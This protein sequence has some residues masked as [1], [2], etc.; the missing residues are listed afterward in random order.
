MLVP[1]KIVLHCSATEDSESKSWGA[2][3]Q[4]HTNVRGW[5]DIGYHYGIERVNGGIYLL[6]GRPYWKRGAHC[7]AE[8]R[9]FDSLGVCVVG[10]FDDK[11]PESDVYQATLDVLKHLCFTFWVKPDDVY[12]HR[13]FEKH[14]TCPG[15]MWDLDKL[16][17]D[18][19]RVVPELDIDAGLLIGGQK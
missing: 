1:S 7:K 15:K 3:K 16:R 19:R 8:N 12:G 10:K 6:R 17:D 11:P 5:L 14:K 18:L 13:E 4:Y 9:N 2:I